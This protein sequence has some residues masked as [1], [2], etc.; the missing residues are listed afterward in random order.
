MRCARRSDG[1]Q[2]SGDLNVN[3]ANL[4]L[5]NMLHSNWEKLPQAC[6]YFICNSIEFAFAFFFPF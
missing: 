4:L 6:V 1:V 5:L 3:L 2:E